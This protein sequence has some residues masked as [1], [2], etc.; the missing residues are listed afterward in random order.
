MQIINTLDAISLP[1]LFAAILFVVLLAIE[2]GYRLGTYR[3][4]RSDKEKEA[5]VGAMVGATLGLLAFL[6]AFT[7]GVA[8]SRFD[9]RRQVLLAEA[10]AI[11]TCYLRGE[12]LPE[13]G[14]EVRSLL[15]QYVEVRLEAVR[16]G[17]VKEAID[18]SE[19]IQRQLW[20][21][22]VTVA[23]ASRDPIVGLFVASL[24]E[25]IDLHAERMQAGLRSRIP[26]AIWVALFAIT[27]LSFAGMGYQEGLAG[28]SRSLAT[29]AV[30][31]A[32]S[33]VIWLIADLDRTGKGSLEVSQQAMIDLQ[34]SMAKPAGKP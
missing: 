22:A 12:M 13:R 5:P 18:R 9:D 28:T 11:G 14:E 21:H 7:F 15:R 2:G 23:G 19:E 20:S 29:I 16:T 31:L 27:L 1:V 4:S 33:S 32:F 17:A 3:Y 30:A 34:Q 24:N 8:A 6:L 10:N 26:G 25:V